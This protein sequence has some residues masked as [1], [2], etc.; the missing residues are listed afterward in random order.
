MA[1]S[2]RPLTPTERI[3]IMTLFRIF[4][5]FFLALLSVYTVMAGQ[6]FGWNLISVF[7]AELLA[8]NWQGQFNLDF[9]G[10][11]SLFAIWCVWRNEYSP[12]SWGL[13]VVG[14]SAGMLFLTIY[15]L[16][17]SFTTSDAKTMLIGERRA[18]Q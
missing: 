6:E 15:L 3:I 9:A 16:Y 2:E 14:A 5:V 17:L 13:A 11:L 18:M 7:F 4:L 10:Y 12:L 1:A 8:V